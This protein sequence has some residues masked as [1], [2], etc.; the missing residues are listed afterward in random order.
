MSPR[1]NSSQK[2]GKI[3]SDQIVAVQ[4]MCAE[5]NINER[6]VCLVLLGNLKRAV[7]IVK[8]R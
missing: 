4:V 2:S 5:T 6:A 8:Y 7:K 1:W 3:T